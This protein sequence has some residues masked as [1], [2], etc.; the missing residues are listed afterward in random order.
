MEEKE[1][2]E[3]KEERKERKKRAIW[4]FMVRGVG[5]WVVDLDTT[6]D[7]NGPNKGAKVELKPVLERG[8]GTTQASATT[9]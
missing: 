8:A 6:N 2:K 3:R 9:E 7:K 4:P 5:G 1:T